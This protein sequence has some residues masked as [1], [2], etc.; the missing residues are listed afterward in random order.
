MGGLDETEVVRSRG[1]SCCSTGSNSIEFGTSLEAFSPPP[2]LSGS[3]EVEDEREVVEEV[4]E[5][6][7]CGEVSEMEAGGGKD[8]WWIDCGSDDSSP[9]ADV[10]AADVGPEV[11]PPASAV[12][13]LYS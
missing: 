6:E 8:E 12:P 3:G 5:D 7:D 13:L 4:V 9:P 11:A 10:E 1:P 2:S